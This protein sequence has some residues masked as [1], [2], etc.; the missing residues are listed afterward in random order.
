MSLHEALSYKDWARAQ[1]IVEE[2]LA[3]AG[4][5]GADELFEG[6][7]PIHL[8]CEHGAPAALLGRLI[9]A[10]PRCVGAPVEACGRFPLHFAVGEGA[11]CPARSV[12]LLLEAV[13]GSVEPGAMFFCNT[14]DAAGR[15]PLHLAVRAGRAGALLCGADVFELLLARAP[16]AARLADGKGCL[17]LHAAAG[18]GTVVWR[19]QQLLA[20]HPAALAHRDGTGKPPL[21]WA[22]L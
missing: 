19:L 17:P 15:T 22:H 10:N 18:F 14:P 20:L 5:A 11:E 9:E 8:A 13:E 2:R 16:A 4:A 3:G 21:H 1:T 7:L 12:A 6:K